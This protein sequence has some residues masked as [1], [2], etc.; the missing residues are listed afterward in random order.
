MIFHSM[1]GLVS[2]LVPMYQSEVIFWAWICSLLD[3]SV[4]CAPKSIRGLIVGLYQ[5]AS[6]FKFSSMLRNEFWQYFS[7][8]RSTPRCHCAECYKGWTKS[9]CM[10]SEYIIIRDAIAT[11]PG[12]HTSYRL[13]SLYNLH[14]LQSSLVEWSVKIFKETLPRFLNLSNWTGSPA[15]KSP[16]SSF[17]ESPGG[18][19]Q[20]PWEAY[21]LTPR[22]ARGPGGSGWNFYC[23]RYR[24]TK[25]RKHQL[26]RLLQ[27][28]R[29]Q[30]WLQDVDWDFDAR[31][32]FYQWPYL[33]VLTARRYS[34]NNLLESTSFVSITRPRPIL[35]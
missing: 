26:S 18:C 35:A 13:P 30:E 9:L 23:A 24:G 4:K 3:N 31:S 22:L 19:P 1:Q 33:L 5:L 27:K 20:G 29:K 32:A 25:F 10:E 7:H 16:L 2:C 8:H 11:A 21:V 34:S 12:T 28:Q 17:E 15:R 14:G 6:G